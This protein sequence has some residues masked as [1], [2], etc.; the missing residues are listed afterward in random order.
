[1][2]VSLEKSKPASAA[3]RVTASPSPRRRNR[4]TV[5]T[6][7]TRATSNAVND[8]AA[9]AGLSSNEVNF[10]RQRG[11]SSAASTEW[12]VDAG[13][14]ALRGVCDALGLKPRVVFGLVR[15]AVTGTSISPGLFES[16]ALLGRDEV[17]ARLSA[18]R[19]LL[20]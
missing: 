1:M 13:E 5:P 16:A 19:S 3:A 18:A 4:G 9:A 20:A 12:T 11:P 2:A 10:C 15:V 7:P 17:L 6:Q 8:I 14:A